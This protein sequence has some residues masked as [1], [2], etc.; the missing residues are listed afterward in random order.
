MAAFPGVEIALKNGTM[1]NFM[2]PLT[3]YLEGSSTADVIGDLNLATA[4]KACGAPAKA[5]DWTTDSCGACW[6]SLAQEGV[7]VVQSLLSDLDETTMASLGKASPYVELIPEVDFAQGCPWKEACEQ[8]LGFVLGEEGLGDDMVK[9]LDNCGGEAPGIDFPG[10]VEELKPLMKAFGVE[11][12]PNGLAGAP[13]MAPA[14]EEKP[15]MEEKPSVPSSGLMA[16]AGLALGVA[17]VL[18][19]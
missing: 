6:E 9:F 5:G 1:Y 2:C 7:K 16:T 12:F 10:L 3:K 19:L 4:L 11:N 17:G 15:S 13:A 14:A 8:N 18:A